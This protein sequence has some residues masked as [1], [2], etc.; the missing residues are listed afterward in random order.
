MIPLFS[1]KNLNY[2][3]IFERF[4]SFLLKFDFAT[5]FSLSFLSASD[6]EVFGIGFL[7]RK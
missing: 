3:N 2:S 4:A 1:L 6:I 7:Q 5:K